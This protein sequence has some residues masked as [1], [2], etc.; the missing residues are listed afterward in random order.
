MADD[1]FKNADIETAAINA[2]APA[3]N[4]PAA[5]KVA[6]TDE[7]KEQALKL[8]IKAEQERFASMPP[9]YVAFTVRYGTFWLVLNL[10]N[11]IASIGMAIGCVK[12]LGREHDQTS[13]SY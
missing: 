1:G 8:R 9:K 7:Q 5:G 13:I 11:I 6:Q 10:F 2:D 4:A 3:A 12:I